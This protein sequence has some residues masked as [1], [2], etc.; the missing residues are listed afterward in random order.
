MVTTAVGHGD[1]RP[2]VV[3]G[4][5]ADRRRQRAANRRVV[6]VVTGGPRLADVRIT[7]VEAEGEHFRRELRFHIEGTLR[8]DPTPEQVVFDTVLHFSSG[9][10]DIAGVRDA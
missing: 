1:A 2:V 6:V 9:E 10:Y 7:V 5:W 3:G 8:M 4:A